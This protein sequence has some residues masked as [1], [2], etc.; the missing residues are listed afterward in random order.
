MDAMMQAEWHAQ[1]A[2]TAGR[3]IWIQT[4]AGRVPVRVA[5]QDRAS[6]ARWLG[7]Y[8]GTDG[9]VRC[10]CRR[11]D[12]IPMGVGCRTAPQETYYLY[13]LHRTDPVRHAWGCP[14]RV[15]G[16][17]TGLGSAKPVVE[18]KNGRINVNLETPLRRGTVRDDDEDAE[19]KKQEKPDGT[20]RDRSASARGKLLTLLQVLWSEAELNVWRPGFAGRRSYGVIRERLLEAADAIAVKGQALGPRLWVPAPYR[21]EREA[22]RD[23]AMQGWLARLQPNAKGQ[24]WYGLVVGLLRGIHAPRPGS[25]AVE[26]AHWRWRLWVPA[27]RWPSWARRWALDRYREDGGDTAEPSEPAMLIALVLREEGRKGPWL[28]V[29]ELAVMPI[30]DTDCWIPVDSGHERRLVQ[31][32]VNEGRRFWKPFAVEIDQEQARGEGELVPDVVLEDRADRLHLEVLGMMSDPAYAAHWVEKARRYAAREQAVWT[33]DPAQQPALPVIPA[34]DREQ[35]RR[36]AAGA[37]QWGAVASGSAP[38]MTESEGR[39]AWP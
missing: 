34:A 4:P 28:A 12:P 1:A 8:H 32:L 11:D 18:L 20:G 31:H 33:W 24:R 29:R 14:H 19:S 3:E 7:P 9:V 25:I 36:A 37:A 16:S 30:A 39:E 6:R 2:Q 13:P 17:G 26:V 35:G 10:L 27:E 21:P 38:R 22:E 5:T 15:S 23:A